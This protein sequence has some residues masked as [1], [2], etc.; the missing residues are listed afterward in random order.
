[1]G[2]AGAAL[3]DEVTETGYYAGGQVKDV[4]GPDGAKTD[5][6]I[7][8]LGR[9]I[10]TTTTVSSAVQDTTILTT[11]AGYDGNGNKVEE[12]DRRGVT[13]E[14]VYDALNRLK[15]VRIIRGVGGEGP[16][17]TIAEYEYDDVGN[18]RFETDLA[19][20]ETEFRYDDLYRVVQK[21]LPETNPMSGQPYEERYTYD[22]VGNRTAVVDAN[23]KATLHEYDS[24]N[25]R[26]K[27][28]QDPIEH[29][30]T[31]A[32]PD[33]L[34]LVTTITYDDA[35]WTSH[36]NKSEEYDQTH[37]LRT[38]FRYDEL[39]RETSRLVHLE[40]AGGDGES[41][42]TTTS[43]DGDAEGP[44]TVATVDPRGVRTV[45][46][47]DGLDRVW[48]EVVD[49]DGLAPAAPLALET[50]RLYDGMGNVKR[51]VNPRGKETNYR[52]DGL[53]RLEQVI[54][55][56]AAKTTFWLDEE[57]LKWK[58]QDRRGVFKEHTY[59]NLGRPRTTTL[60]PKFTEVGWSQEIEY[61]DVQ[62][63]RI[64]RDAK[65]R[66]T[67]YTLDGL[68]RVILAKD[69]EP[70]Q[71][72]TV[73]AEWDGVNKRRVK[74]RAGEWTD[75]EYDAINRLVKTTDPV[76]TGASEATFTETT[77]A[78]DTNQRAERD[79]RGIETV[80][81]LDPLGRVKTVTRAGIVVERNQ[82]DGNGNR[83]ETTD[84]EGKRTLFQYD[85]ANRLSD[86][87]EGAGSAE[88]ATTHFEYDENGN[89]TL[90]LDPRAAALGEEFSVKNT[91]DELD[92][93]ET[94]TDGEG[95]VTTYGYDE[96]GNR[97]YVRPRSAT[98]PSAS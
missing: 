13:R 78:D 29:N 39:N 64:E 36:V 82:Y 11:S 32:N 62:R 77:Y 17:G 66:A 86:R 85:A 50:T 33:G 30:P 40:G 58:E 53:G 35:D 61:Q 8:G 74:D 12:T 3:G 69:P 15:E 27:T 90:E 5:Y 22:K 38:T 34:N 70:F 55:H 67:T 24:L 75:Y 80:T 44:H 42:E 56:T 16:L 52:Y 96:E 31:G 89:L 6:A 63:H 83:T 51:E 23:G 46:Y 49:T 76:L 60:T 72:Q 92:R 93:L 37:G 4:T 68:D 1:M 14:N 79:R 25:R 19:G 81:Q 10:G 57:G 73:E 54:D 88:A 2:P 43:Y 47:L 94:V 7:D 95:N 48:K 45:R 97:T 71:G 20:Q 87:T 98:T 9:V 84:G 41:Y 18:K 65:G 21:I 26:T 59:D 91:Y 28:I